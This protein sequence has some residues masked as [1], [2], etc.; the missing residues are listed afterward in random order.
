MGDY[1]SDRWPPAPGFTEE[2]LNDVR[3]VTVHPAQV[4]A[5]VGVVLMMCATL[6]MPYDFYVILRWAA[7]AMAIWVCTVAGSQHR[8]FWVVAMLAI[9]V[10]FN[11][12]VPF[13]MPRGNWA[14]LNTISLV[15]FGAAGV[16][17]RASRPAT[18]A[19][20]RWSP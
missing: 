17:L 5:I 6:S 13:T 9:A 11:P 16:K 2:Q 18:E 3:L 1:S 12:I 8:T 19:D 15:L 4:P 20:G 10:V 7:P 14:W